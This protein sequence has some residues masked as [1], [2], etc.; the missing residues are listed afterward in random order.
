[1]HFGRGDDATERANEADLVACLRAH[2][3]AVEHL[4]LLGDVF[5]QFIEY[6]HLIPKGQ[7]RFQALLAEWSD[8]GIPITY[9]VGNHDPWHQDYFA[10]ELGVRV[11]FDGLIEPIDGA[12]VYLSHGDAVVTHSRLYP[13]LRPLLRHPVPVWLY[14]TLLP[15]DSGYRLARWVN[16]RLR[17]DEPDPH[18]GS[19]LRDHARKMLADT[20]AEI[21]IM[22]HSHIPDL[23][24]WPDGCYLN[25][26]NWYESRTFGRLDKN[27]LHLLRWNGTQAIDI[28]A[29]QIHR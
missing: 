29:A 10:E 14:R 19:A 20:A 23:Q 8:Q 2:E 22:S 24:R 26:G 13:Y 3:D 27:S 18:L 21:A 15:A 25:T 1:M 16:R 4:Y 7:I 5:D 11:V 28:E 12:P 6:R 17:T 9:L